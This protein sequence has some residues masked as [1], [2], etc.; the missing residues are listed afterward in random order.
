MVGIRGRAFGVKRR[1]AFGVLAGRCRG[2]LRGWLRDRA[3]CSGGSVRAR[4]ISRLVRASAYAGPATTISGATATRSRQS[5]VVDDLVNQS[6][7]K[8]LFAADP[9][10]GSCQLKRAGM[11][12]P[13]NKD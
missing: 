1:D 6:Q 3:S 11:A 12:E 5:V 7:R 4:L 8:G 10:A 9:S 2:S 13:M